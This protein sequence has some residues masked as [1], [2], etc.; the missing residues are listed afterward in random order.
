M[1]K[2]STHIVVKQIKSVIGQSERTRQT[3]RGLGLRKIGHEVKLQDT[4]AIRGM[5]VKVQHLVDVAVHKGSVEK[6]GMRHKG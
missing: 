3:V 6:F 1:A 5:V 2:A 4:P